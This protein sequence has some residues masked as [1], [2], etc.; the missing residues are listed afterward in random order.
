MELKYICL[1]ARTCANDYLTKCKG[2]RDFTGGSNNW[3]EHGEEND[4]L[5][6]EKI[7]KILK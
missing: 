2:Q 5:L 1:L 4:E 3:L 6:V 7:K